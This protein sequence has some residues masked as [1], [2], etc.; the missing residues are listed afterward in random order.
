MILNRKPL[1]LSFSLAL[2]G[3]LGAPILFQA[4]AQASEAD[5][6]IPSLDNLYN[7]FGMSV[8]GSTL[9]TWGMGVAVLGMVFGL[10]E[11]NKIRK[12]P[13]HRSMLDVSSLIYE[14]CK[15]YL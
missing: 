3:V 1:T 11:S 10:L 2:A 13:A 12:L 8:A 7:L 15:T 4:Q 5:L 14:T 9:L 6:R